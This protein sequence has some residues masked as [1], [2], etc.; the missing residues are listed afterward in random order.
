MLGQI[1]RQQREE[2]G[3]TQAELAGDFTTASYISLIE[4]GA[5]IPS[6]R[7]LRGIAERLGK[8]AYFFEAMASDNSEAAIRSKIERLR[9]L[10]I[11]NQLDA[12]RDLI[13]EIE[14]ETT[15]LLDPDNRGQ[16]YMAIA[17][18][19]WAS[20]DLDGSIA[21]Y[22]QAHDVFDKLGYRH[23]VI[24]ALYGL[25]N[26][27]M[28]RHDLILAMYYFKKAL[29][30][31]DMEHIS[32]PKLL[33]HL[34][35]SLANCL[36]RLG[37]FGEAQVIY[38][39]LYKTPDV[40]Y[41]ERI[42][43]LIAI[44]LTHQRNG[45]AR[46]ALEYSVEARR[47]AEDYSDLARQGTAHL[48]SA[49]NLRDLGEPETANGH[50]DRA[51]HIFQQLGM[52]SDLVS[53]KIKRAQMAIDSKDYAVADQL[54]DMVADE[55]LSQAALAQT[56]AELNRARSEYDQAVANYIQASLIYEKIEHFES[57]GKA[58]R[59]A[60][61]TAMQGGGSTKAAE[62]LLK[63]LDLYDRARKETVETAL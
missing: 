9:A 12:A 13:A 27:H 16:Y 25:G 43:T 54:L 14:S 22:K 8:P 35:S 26:I 10:A 3:M 6:K 5:A 50:L 52:A 53:A 44:S 19:S 29:A 1:I 23:K 34:R 59:K 51:E 40:G 30:L 48:L 24:Q 32:D 31:E 37:R 55:P 11:G 60:A 15:E 20:G 2:R 49:S 21:Y 56:R 45:D 61:E 38:D 36:F 58:L 17:Y 57:A 42:S 41:E 33:F 46:K 62:F 39:D 7:I 4:R 63:A 47:L 18:Y 28:R